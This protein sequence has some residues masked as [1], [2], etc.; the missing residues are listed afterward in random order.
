MFKNYYGGYNCID[1]DDENPYLVYG[2]DS[3]DSI[4]QSLEVILAPCNYVGQF[5]EPTIP[6]GCT[7]D[8]Q[9]QKNYLTDNLYLSILSNQESLDLQKFEN[10]TIIKQSKIYDQVFKAKES[11][12]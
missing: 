8:L 12:T 4:F 3:T 1:W 10:E 7:Y 5:G 2:D 11:Y 6:P 9:A